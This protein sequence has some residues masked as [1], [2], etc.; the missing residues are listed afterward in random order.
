MAKAARFNPAMDLDLFHLMVEDSDRSTV[1]ADPD[2]VAD[3][4]PE[5]ERLPHDWRQHLPSVSTM[6]I[7]SNWIKD[8]SSVGLIVPSA[9][10][11]E[12]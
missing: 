11:T 12:E 2:L 5:A 6:R 1:P 4:P 9:I 8:Q 3:E 10:V 7:G